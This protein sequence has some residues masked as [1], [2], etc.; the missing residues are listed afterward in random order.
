VACF[1]KRSH[2][3]AVHK[4]SPYKNLDDLKNAFKD[5]TIKV[6]VSGLGGGSHLNGA[7]FVKALGLG[8]VQYVPFDSEAELTTALLGKVVDLAIPTTLG[9]VRSHK[10]GD[11]RLLAV[12]F[13]ESLEDLPEV[14][15]M[16]KLGFKGN[17]LETYTVALAPPGLP[18]E[19]QEK[20]S[21]AFYE[22]SQKEEHKDWA[23]KQT[24]INTPMKLQQ[25]E[26][27]IKQ[28]YQIVSGMVDILK[29]QASK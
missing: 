28:Q 25:L 4:D 5:K 17:Y 16:G 11:I 13:D 7:L 12:F 3:A 15:A 10:A 23:K 27:L 29:V 14:P 19:I 8:K 24:L 6:G 2:A 26:N 21:D 1:S 20:L 22:A 9:G 18:K